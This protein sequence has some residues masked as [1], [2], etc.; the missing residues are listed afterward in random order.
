[1][2]LEWSSKPIEVAHTTVIKTALTGRKS[3]DLRCLAIEDH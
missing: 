1:M 3:A 2:G